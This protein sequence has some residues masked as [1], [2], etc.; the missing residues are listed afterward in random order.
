M[1]HK[2]EAA[3]GFKL[4]IKMQICVCQWESLNREIRNVLGKEHWEYPNLMD[5]R[6]E[7]HAVI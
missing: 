1:E 6:V 7:T 3:A 4:E 5:E 2:R